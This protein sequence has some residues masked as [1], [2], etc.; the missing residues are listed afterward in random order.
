MQQLM[1][2]SVKGL[3]FSIEKSIQRL[4]IESVPGLQISI[5]KPSQKLEIGAVKGLEI[6]IEKPI[7]KLEIGTVQGLDFS[8]KEPKLRKLT[9]STSIS[10]EE[11]S[12]LRP[13]LGYPHTEM[14]VTPSRNNSPWELNTTSDPSQG[15]SVQQF[16]LSPNHVPSLNLKPNPIQALIPKS[17]PDV[18]TPTRVEP[19]KKQLVPKINLSSLTTPSRVSLP[20]ITPPF[21]EIRSQ[22]IT[23]NDG[24]ES[25]RL[26]QESANA[27]LE[28]QAKMQAM[29]T[30]GLEKKA[31]SG[32]KKNPDNQPNLLSE[33]KRPNVIKRTC[34]SFKSSGSLDK[35]PEIILPI[36]MGDLQ[37]IGFQKPEPKTPPKV[38]IPKLSMNLINSPGPLGISS[39]F[40][41]PDTTE[42]DLALNPNANTSRQ[43]SE[44]LNSDRLNTPRQLDSNLIKEKIDF[45][46]PR[47]SSRN[48]TQRS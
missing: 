23:S 40:R 48:Q 34:D 30:K 5:E 39:T 42:R 33:K 46:A 19:K 12:L 18:H 11:E 38:F 29:K 4:K 31:K 6:P 44:R 21:T 8:T 22:Q 41:V 13:K 16:S 7:Q 15:G 35:S 3:E 37:G 47:Q 36:S 25:H 28:L 27:R 2:E 45:Y 10:T 20:T 24:S 9:K 26:I 43:N 14:Q 1:V 32:T 17:N